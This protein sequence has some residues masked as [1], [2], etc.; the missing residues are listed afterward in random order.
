ML[1]WR[2][3]YSAPF[4]YCLHKNGDA[5]SQV[6]KGQEVKLNLLHLKSYM[7]NPWITSHFWKLIILEVREYLRAVVESTENVSL[8]WVKKDY[9]EKLCI[10]EIYIPK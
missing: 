6:D 8:K 2:L 7:N 9:T 1:C 10:S 4:V 5:W 3:K